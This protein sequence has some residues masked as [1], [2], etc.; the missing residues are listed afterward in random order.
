MSPTRRPIDGHEPAVVTVIALL[1]EVV[2]GTLTLMA[3]RNGNVAIVPAGR[4]AMAAAFI[5]LYELVR[6]W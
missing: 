6:W 1:C 2:S 3:N 4:D 5:A